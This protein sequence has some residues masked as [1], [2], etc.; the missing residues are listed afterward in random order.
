[1]PRTVCPK[2][3]LRCICTIPR[4]RNAAMRHAHRYSCPFFE[5]FRG[6]LQRFHAAIAAW[7]GRVPRCAQASGGP[8]E[9]RAAPRFGGGP[10]NGPDGSGIAVRLRGVPGAGNHGI[11]G[12]ILP[13]RPWVARDSP[14]SCSRGSL[15]ETFFRD[16]MAPRGPT[17]GYHMLCNAKTPFPHE[18]DL[19]PK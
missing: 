9:C 1:M 8:A 10:P 17:F 13:I 4:V 18:P 16:F 19:F 2:L 11:Q 5:R 7:T 3:D 12:F 6:V 14:I 15:V